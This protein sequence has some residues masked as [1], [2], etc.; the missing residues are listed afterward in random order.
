MYVESLFTAEE[1]QTAVDD[2]FVRQFSHPTRPELIGLDYSPSAQ[3]ANHWT[4]VTL[5]SRGFVYNRDSGLIVVRCMPKFFNYTEKPLPHH[6][7]EQQPMVFDKVDGSLGLIFLDDDGYRVMTRGSFASDQALWAT[8]W[9]RREHPD[10][11]QPEDVTTLVEIIYPSNRIV[12]DYGTTAELVLI[13]AISKSTGEDIPLW[14]IDWWPGSVVTHHRGFKNLDE[15]YAFATSDAKDGEEGIVAVWYRPG[16]VS[17][18]CKIKHPEY[19]R[20]HRILTN[21][22]SKNIWEYLRHGESLEPLLEVVPD[23]FYQWVHS[24]VDDLNA[25]YREI[26]ERAQ[27]D[28]AKIAHIENRKDFAFAAHGLKGNPGLLFAIHDGFDYSDAIWKMIKPAYEK[29]FSL[30]D[31]D[32]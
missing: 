23:E 14:N 3:Y 4:S 15:T 28:Y 30:Q 10:F 18:R 12:V 24:V 22:S 31:R 13:A 21:V 2:G 8:E 16:E 1:L 9:L 7:Y 25:K 20:L 26:E 17:A 19:V 29:P 5:N 32:L 6:C 27:A 11:T